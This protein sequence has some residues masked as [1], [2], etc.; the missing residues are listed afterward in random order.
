[1]GEEQKQEQQQQQQQQQR[2]EEEQQQ[3][4]A[5][6]ETLRRA[7]WPRTD[8]LFSD[9][10]IILSTTAAYHLFSQ[11]NQLATALLAMSPLEYIDKKT[12]ER[13]KAWYGIYWMTGR[14]AKPFRMYH[15]SK[16]ARWMT[17]NT[18]RAL[19]CLVCMA[20]LRL[21]D[22]KESYDPTFYPLGDDVKAALKAMIDPA[23]LHIIEKE[24]KEFL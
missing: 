7:G 2:E 3:G 5:L 20:K 11:D 6:W 16:T 24:S 4:D 18:S 23:W 19:P 21:K 1:M 12:N 9:N 17:E 22:G 14:G 15:C 13:A 10:R 8:T